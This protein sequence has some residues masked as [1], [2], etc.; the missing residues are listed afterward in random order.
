MMTIDKLNEKFGIKDGIEFEKRKNDLIFLKISNKYANAEVC[1]YGAHI[2]SFI[3]HGSRDVLWMS[4]AS[5]F[6]AGKPVRGGIP[7]CFPWFGP[8]QTDP[9]KPQHGFARLMFWELTEIITA[10]NGET[11]V[12]LQLCSSAITNNYWPSGFCAELIMVVGKTLKV[13]LKVTNTSDKQFNYSCAL[14]SYYNIADIRHIAIDGLSG[15][16]YHNHLQPGEFFQESGKLEIQQAETRHY[17]NTAAACVIED[18]IFNRKILAAKSGSKVTTVWNPGES[19]CTAIADLPDDGFKYFIC[20]EAV[21]SF[22]DIIILNPGQS[23]ETSAIIGL[24]E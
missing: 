19:A 8:H 12:S 10:L 6:E 15:T 1:L 23:H 13:S 20:I 2:T 21:N 22:E 5:Y 11:R 14:H 18:P 4:P 9:A 3:P 24:G 17:H 16:L 7:V